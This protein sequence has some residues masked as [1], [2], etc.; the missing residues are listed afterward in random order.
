MIVFTT[1]T[2]GALTSTAVATT[3]CVTRA[4][5]VISNSLMCA[6]T[7]ASARYD[8]SMTERTSL[9]EATKNATF[10]FVVRSSS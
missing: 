7:P 5:L 1:C 3:S 2:T 10:D 8:W 4:E 9:G 6:A